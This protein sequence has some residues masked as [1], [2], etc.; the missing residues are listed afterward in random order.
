MTKTFG[1]PAADYEE[2]R[3][4]TGDDE[5]WIRTFKN[6]TTKIRICPATT[7][8]KRGKTITGTDAWPQEWEHYDKGFGA[9]PCDDTS[10]CVGCTDPNEEVSKKVQKFYFNAID[11]KG[12]TRVYKIGVKFYRIMQNREAKLGTLS[13]RDYFVNKMGTG[14]DTTYELESGEKYDIDFSEVQVHD[15]VAILT[16]RYELAQQAYGGESFAA[17][18][19]DTPKEERVQD[20]PPERIAPQGRIVPAGKAEPKDEPSWS[21]TGSKATTA[22]QDT[23]QDSWGNKPTEE[24]ITSAETGTIK[25]WLDEQEVEYPS[26]AARERLIKAAIEKSEANP[27]Y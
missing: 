12:Y 10:G 17:K 23:P 7:V 11:E 24:Q 14:F 16:H 1:A 15:I 4:V 13:D 22:V 8:N 3:T 18:S 9:W 21:E 26:R 5:I 27:P 6:P 19:D 2:T 25:L 20:T